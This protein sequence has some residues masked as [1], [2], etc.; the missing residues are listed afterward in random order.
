MKRTLPAEGQSIGPDRQAV[1][2]VSA[3]LL[4]NGS[5]WESSP[6]APGSKRPLQASAID[7]PTV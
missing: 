6:T 4:L 7:R 5:Y 2:S 1:Q 3:P